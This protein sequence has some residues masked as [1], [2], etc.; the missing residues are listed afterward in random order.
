MSEVDKLIE[1]QNHE[2]YALFDKLAKNVSKKEQI[3]ILKANIQ[4]IPETKTE[5]R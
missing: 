2:Y 5:V 3:E 1:T 4:L